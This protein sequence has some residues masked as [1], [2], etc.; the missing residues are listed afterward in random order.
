MKKIL[1]IL[2]IGIS[3][4]SYADIYE[5]YMQTGEAAYIEKNYTESLNFYLSAF[6][7]NTGDLEALLGVARSYEGLNQ[8]DNA[9]GVYRK[10]LKLDP[11]NIGAHRKKLNLDEKNV[12]KWGYDQKEEYFEEFEKFLKKTNYSNSEDIYALGRIYMNDKSFERAYKVFKRDKNNDYR[13]YFGVATTAR[14]LG[15]YDTSITY[16]KKLLSIKPNFYRGYLGLGSSYKMKG[17]YTAAIENMEKYLV[18]E[19]DENVYIAMADIYIAQ[20]K[21][22][23]AKDVLEEAQSKF[24]DSKKI[25]KN[26]GDIY[27]KLGRN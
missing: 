26:L 15:K 14:F 6:K 17:N 1:I 23:S 18:Y 3:L 12:S 16:Y 27:S 20:D 21:Y 5:D 11:K 24:S 2:F 8:I 4:I 7:E 22:S 19:E 10:V 25:R 9:L 13:N